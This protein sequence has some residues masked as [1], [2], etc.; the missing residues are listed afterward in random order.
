MSARALASQERAAQAQRVSRLTRSLLLLLATLLLFTTLGLLVADQLYRPDTFVIDQLKIK[1]KFRYLDPADVERVVKANELGNFFT[2]DLQEIKRQSEELPWVQR[3]DVRREWP[4]TLLISLEE[5]QPVMRWTDNKWVN[6]YGEVVELPAQKA[7]NP[8]I[9]LSGNPRDA[10]LMMQRAIE[11]EQ[12]LQSNGLQ[13][14]G[15]TLSDSHAFRLRIRQASGLDPFELLLGRRDV[16]SRL[17]RFLQL[18]QSQLRTAG[19][20][21]Q[22]VDARYP[23]GLAIKSK[24]LE[25]D[26]VSD[27]EPLALNLSSA[28]RGQTQ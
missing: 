8:R 20:A 22:R 28:P 4:N 9:S 1:G 24:K 10:K 19:I 14:I 27:S 25:T 2:V 13:L 6:I 17:T 18:Y 7:F 15:L 23:D 5:Q 11:W 3:A 12:Q 16:E 26:D 21:L